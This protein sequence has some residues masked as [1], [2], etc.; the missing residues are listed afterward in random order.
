MWNLIVI[1]FRVALINLARVM[2]SLML[3]NSFVYIFAKN[4]LCKD[5]YYYY[6]HTTN[7]FT[8]YSIGACALF[9][10]LY[11]VSKTN[12]NIWSEL[13]RTITICLIMINVVCL[14]YTFNGGIYIYLSLYHIVVLYFFLLVKAIIV[15]KLIKKINERI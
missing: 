13:N 7:E 15:G 2:P 4:Y 1:L 14:I 12:D 11:F 9:L 8:G 10:Y 3:L 6:Y 5:C